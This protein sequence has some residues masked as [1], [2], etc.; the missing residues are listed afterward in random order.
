M[1]L[2]QKDYTGARTLLESAYVAS[3]SG[4]VLLD[5]VQTYRGLSLNALAL[6]TL[7]QARVTGSPVLAAAEAKAVDAQITELTALTYRLQLQLPEG[8]TTLQLDGVNFEPPLANVPL[9]LEPGLHALKV[10]KPNHEAYTKDVNAVAGQEATLVVELQAWVNT[11]RV[12]VSDKGGQVLNVY[13]DGIQ[14]GTTPWEGE[15]PVG[16]HVIEGRNERA[17]AEARTIDLPRRAVV[18]VVLD[19]VVNYERL[20]INSPVRG[21]SA[22]LDGQ[23]IQLPFDQVVLVGE[24]QLRV[25]APG[26]SPMEKTLNVEANKPVN[27]QVTLTGARVDEM[28]LAREKPPEPLRVGVLLGLVSVPRPINVEVSLKP[29][30]FLGLGVGFS[31]IPEV[32]ISDFSANMYAVN[33]VGRIFPFQGA[34]YLGLGAGIQTMGVEA[35]DVIQGERYTGS[36]DH[37]A[38]F[39]TPQLG[40]LWIWDSGFALGLNVGVQVPVTSSPDVRVHDSAGNEVDPNDYGQRAVELRDDVSDVAKYLGFFPL[41]A[42]DLLKIGFFF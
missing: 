32:T 4:S 23:Q 11:G 28:D 30:E 27:E 42:V 15:L 38:F 31:M 1:L 17:V 13:V 19:S 35:D 2:K 16:N 34:F 29:N 10:E 25:T 8:V 26:H 6:Q 33:A 39:L 40:W 5:L 36:V 3:P 18:D 37:T 41:P 20:I 7:L 12:K 22:T 21:A 24:H 14:V 9:V